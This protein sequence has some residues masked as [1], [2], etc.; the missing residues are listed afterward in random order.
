MHQADPATL[1][2]DAVTAEIRERRTPFVEVPDT[3]Q[4][5]QFGH[6]NG[7]SAIY[8][9]YAWSDV[10][11]RDLWQQ[12]EGDVMNAETFGRYKDEVLAAGGSRDAAD[13]VTSFLGRPF[14]FDAYEAW[15]AR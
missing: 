13:M 10:I 7:Y 14:S 6:L 2:F 15:L 1:D 9:T 3:H 12:F 8:Y 4:P 11:A 5:A